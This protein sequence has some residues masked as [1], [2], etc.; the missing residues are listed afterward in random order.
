MV[1]TLTE[2]ILQIFIR[3]PVQLIG[4]FLIALAV[5][6]VEF[7]PL[8]VRN[9]EAAG[10]VAPGE[11]SKTVS[12]YVLYFV[13]GLETLPLIKDIVLIIFW[14]GVAVC[15]YLLFL[16]VSNALIV[17]RNE[18]VVDTQYTRGDTTRA[19]ITHFGN[20]I[21]AAF[22]FLVLAGL[23]VV[24]LIPY[25]M[26]MLK[27]FAS[28]PIGFD[29]AHYFLIGFFGLMANIYVVWATAYFTWIYEESV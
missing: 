18:Y 19:L 24:F 16:A 9:F 22:W 2:K 20:K 7:S 26:D 25:F 6:L 4:S 1:N 23:S 14:G 17:I 10:E 8:L 27:I 12:E 11:T 3:T 28:T 5:F 13:K 21:L 29:T 15:A